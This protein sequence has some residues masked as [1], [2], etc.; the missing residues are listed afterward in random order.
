MCCIVDFTAYVICFVCFDVGDVAFVFVGLFVCLL[1]DS[2]LIAC[3]RSSKLTVV[4][5]W[6]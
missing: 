3:M 1:P 6:W 2:G 5:V 4:F